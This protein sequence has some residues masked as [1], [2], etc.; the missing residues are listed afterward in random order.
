MFDRALYVRLRTILRQHE[1]IKMHYLTIRLANAGNLDFI[2]ECAH[3]A[4]QPYVADIGQKPAPMIADFASHLARG[5]LYILEAAERPVGYIVWWLNDDDL[6]VDNIAILPGQ[7]GNG[8][9]GHCFKQLE[10]IARQN[11]RSALKLYTNEKMY[12]NLNLYQHLGFEEIQRIA[13]NG[14]NRVYFRKEL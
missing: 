1:S 3:E 5:E 12:G 13:E 9:A 2:S 14:F 6:F 8:F 4:Y 11:G 10:E 7:Q